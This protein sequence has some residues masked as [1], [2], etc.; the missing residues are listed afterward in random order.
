[1][2]GVGQIFG[3][4]AAGPLSQRIGR[5]YTAMSFAAVTVCRSTRICHCECLLN[6]GRLLAWLCSLLLRVKADY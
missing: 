6:N 1:M 3:S 5:R 2:T 4:A